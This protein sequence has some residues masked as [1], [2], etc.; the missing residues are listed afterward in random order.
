MANILIIDDDKLIRAILSERMTEMGHSA[1][2]AEFLREGTE[3]AARHDFDLVFLDVRLPDGN[4]LDAI[5]GIMGGPGAPEVIIITA[6]GDADGASMAVRSGAWDYLQKPF[7]AKEIMLQV[8]RVL[9]YRRRKEAGNQPVALKRERIVGRGPELTACL[10]RI[11]QSA[12]T[13]ANVLITG[14]TGTG[15]ELFARALHEN[16]RRADR[17]FVVVDCTVLPEN[18]VESTL[19]GHVKGAFTGAGEAAPGLI[20][21][22]DGGTLFLDE[23]GDLPLPVQK[24]FLRVLQ[25]RKYRPVGGSR[26][27][28]S[29]FRLVS[30]TNRDLEKMVDRGDFRRDLLYR[31]K[32]F[33][34]ELPPLRRRAGDI[35][36]LVLHHVHALGER[37]G[38]TNRGVSPDAMLLL[39]DYHWPGNIRELISTLEQA[40]LSD[41]ACPI[42]YPKHLPEAIRFRHLAAGPAH[43]GDSLNGEDST[44][45]ERNGDFKTNLQPEFE[46][47][48]EFNANTGPEFGR[49][50]GPGSEIGFDS[51]A[52]TGR[53]TMRDGYSGH[54][55]PPFGVSGKGLEGSRVPGPENGYDRKSGWEAGRRDVGSG[56]AFT[57]LSKS[58][59]SSHDGDELPEK[60]CDFPQMK[61][62]RNAVM[63]RAEAHYLRHLLK[64]VE[65]DIRKAVI[66]S[67]LSRARL[68]A[69]IK[70]YNLRSGKA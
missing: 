15:K 13:D 4:G 28:Q 59:I 20:A 3:L 2:V 58:E 34:I 1:A 6:V 16:S 69:L 19:F 5:G 55:Q 12:A 9:E 51:G 50:V 30:A 22:A 40:I 70:K 10:D 53:E 26:E 39:V 67:G 24:S 43:G 47:S 63:E 45:P 60:S 25:E 62:Y 8:T 32:T 23:V 46:R 36:E 49:A 29:N 61:E 57:P 66:V 52:G 48:G 18:L 44:E 27:K 56:R 37:H 68:Y 41:P 31:L 54:E 35:R 11:A 17:G 38:L 42:L 7:S 65:G 33:G 64:A 21:Q 14:E